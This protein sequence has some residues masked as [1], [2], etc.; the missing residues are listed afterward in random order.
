MTVLAALISLTGACW[1]GSGGAT[2]DFGGAEESSLTITIRNQR[3]QEARL[4]IWIDGRREPLGT[5][6]GVQTETFRRRLPA[7]AQVRLEFDL[8]LGPTCRTREVSLEPGT[9][10]DVVLPTNLRLMD[11]RCER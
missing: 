6:Q 3:T 4:W 5:V 8:T 1:G 2:P 11:V 10:L 9:V 7:V